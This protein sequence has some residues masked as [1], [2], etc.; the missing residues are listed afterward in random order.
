MFTNV[1]A[2]LLDY[3]VD[4]DLEFWRELFEASHRELHIAL[5]HRLQS[6]K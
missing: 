3:P 4:D 2:A 5:P 6:L 1:V